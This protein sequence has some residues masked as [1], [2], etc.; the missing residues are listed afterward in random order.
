MK[1]DG[2]EIK[3]DQ[4]GEEEGDGYEGEEGEEEEEED[5]E[6]GIEK[7]SHYSEAD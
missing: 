4:M 7:Y 6:D 1:E 3:E 5:Q 2:E